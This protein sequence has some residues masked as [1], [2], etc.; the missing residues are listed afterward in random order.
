MIRRDEQVQVRGARVEL[1]EVENAVRE[2]GFIQVDWFQAVRE[3]RQ[4]R[5]PVCT[6]ENVA[7]RP[8]MRAFRLHRVRCRTYRR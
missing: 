8:Q 3:P 5:D 2:R 4:F 6:P 7:A 1:K